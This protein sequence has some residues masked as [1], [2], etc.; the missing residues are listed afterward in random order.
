MRFAAAIGS[1]SP[2][3]L[4]QGLRR[5]LVCPNHSRGKGPNQ[6][7]F[8]PDGNETSDKGVW[9]SIWVD[10]V[11]AVHERCVTLFRITTNLTRAR[12]AT[13]RPHVKRS[14]PRHRS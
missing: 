6:S 11:D 1:L 13:H 5:D 4:W 10:N 9:M 12:H 14:N 2:D 3:N 8:G 7:T